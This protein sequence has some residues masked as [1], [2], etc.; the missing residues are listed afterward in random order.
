[1]KTCFR[2][3]LV[4]CLLLAGPLH[5]AEECSETSAA[6]LWAA[7]E[8]RLG[9]L[10]GTR[11]LLVPQFRIYRTIQDLP[12]QQGDIVLGYY[13]FASKGI[14]V[15]CHDGDTNVFARNVRHESTHYYLHSAYGQLPGWLS[16]G[17][18]TYMEDGSLEEASL[19]AHINRKRLD[20][21]I[22]L[23]RKGKAPSLESLLEERNFSQPSYFYASSWA[24]TFSLLH[25][26]DEGIQEERRALLRKLLQ[27]A[28]AV[29]TD[30]GTTNKAFVT[31]VSRWEGDSISWQRKWHREVWSLR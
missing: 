3:G 16:E 21:F 29:K 9:E 5:A 19:S 31:E 27:V 13:D 17:L 25:H 23:L 30:V 4:L 6:S 24:L 22:H 11:V 2:I 8:A 20:E 7:T 28:R 26:A 14:A 1:M 10:F 18:A 15:A 12:K